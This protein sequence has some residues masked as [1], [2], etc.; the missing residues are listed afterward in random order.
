M[1]MR[2]TIRPFSTPMATPISTPPA[3]PR[4][5]GRPRFFIS[6]AQITPLKAATAP[7]ERSIPPVST[8]RKLPMAMIETMEICRRMFSR[9]SEEMNT[10]CRI[11]SATHHSRNARTRP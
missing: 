9:F 3:I 6:T 4:A 5:M 11:T 7:T 1:R 8:T 10:G 2:V